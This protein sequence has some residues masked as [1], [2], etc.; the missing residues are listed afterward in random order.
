MS[1]EATN[2]AAIARITQIIHAALLMGVL[3][4]GGMVTLMPGRTPPPQDGPVPLSWI[5]GAIA[6]MVLTASFAAPE[7]VAGALRKAIGLGKD[8]IGPR[9]IAIDMK[10]A[11]RLAFAYQ[12][13]RIIGFA[14]V[15]GAAFLSLI[16]FMITRDIIGLALAGICVLVLA[17]RFVTRDRLDAWVSNQLR[18]L[19]E[20][21]SGG[22]I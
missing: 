4:F 20:E 21:R 9:G 7:V 2:G 14:M 16:N 3:T 8:K 13:T 1:T 15:E 17:S 19:E 12:T 18:L 22:V 6:G 5:L 11:D 10:E